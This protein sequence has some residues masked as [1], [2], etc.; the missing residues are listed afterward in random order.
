MS[1]NKIEGG[2]GDEERELRF[3]RLEIEALQAEV[4]RAKASEDGAL[5]AVAY[6]QK[7]CEKQ[8][9]ALR[10]ILQLVAPRAGMSEH[11]RIDCRC[12]ECRITRIAR[13]ALEKKAEGK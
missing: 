4:E 3:A 10:E 7:R 8:E 1:N 11:R 12:V 6:W 2:S 9:S 13:A 5:D